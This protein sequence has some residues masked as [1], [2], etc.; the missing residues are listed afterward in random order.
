VLVLVLVLVLLVVDEEAG[1]VVL[2]GQTRR[3]L[4][5]LMMCRFASEVLEKLLLSG[6]NGQSVSH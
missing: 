5:I 1:R 3:A 4:F 2:Q 6:K